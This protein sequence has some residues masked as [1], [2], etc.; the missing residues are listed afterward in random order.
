MSLYQQVR[1]DDLDDVV[2]NSSTV[3]AFRKIL[4]SSADS[5]S[6]AILLKGP[7]G[8]G[9]T[10]LARILAKGVGCSEDSI[11]ELNAANTNGID[12]IREVDRNSRLLGIGGSVKTYI[13]DESHELTAKAQEGLLKVI[14]D[15]PP[16]CYFIFCTTSPEKIIKTI[17]NRCAEYQ[18]GLLTNDE[19]IKVLEQACKKIGVVP[20]QVHDKIEA[21]SLTCE[22]SPRAALV[23][24]EQVIGI[25][26]IDEALELIVQ[27]TP[28]D[29]N[30][31]DLLKL[32]C[33]APAVRRKKWKKIILIFDAIEV[34]PEVIRRSI[35]TFLYNKLK[36]YDK[37]EDAEDIARLLKLFSTSVYYGGKS[38]LGALIVRA[39]FEI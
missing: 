23:T 39:C 34:E 8:C 21:I 13:F 1:P 9:K 31:I 33:A 36:I 14:E 25:E 3:G 30:I 20:S 19:I 11:F 38:Q 17:R 27:G 28:K 5:R 6:H 32:L 37:I 22:G 2:G 7:S 4:R 10:T 12:T 24:F 18:V 35:L 16:H 26:D 15:N 29:A